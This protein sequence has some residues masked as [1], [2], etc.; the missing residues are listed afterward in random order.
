MIFSARN[1]NYPQPKYAVWWLTQFRRWGMVEGPPDYA[2]VARQVMRADLYEEAMKEI[3]VK[4]GGRDDKPETLFDGKLF[5]PAKA[6]A[7][8][9]SFAV[10]SVK[11]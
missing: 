8:A 3:G 6:E 4:H 9:R 1:C 11:G 2:G 5:D 10:N 7:Y